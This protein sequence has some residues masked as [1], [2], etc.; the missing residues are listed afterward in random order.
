MAARWIALVIGALTFAIVGF[1]VVIALRPPAAPPTSPAVS[2]EDGA[3]EQRMMTKPW[4][5]SAQIQ[6]R[7]IG[8]EVM[9]SIRDEAGRPAIVLTAPRAELRMLEMSMAPVGLSLEQTAPGTWRGRAEPTMSGRWS[10]VVTIEGE[11][12]SFPFTAPVGK[13]VA[14]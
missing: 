8:L 4:T 14:S 13:P 2:S 12:L 3:A 5:V 1:F 6:P 7:P 10:F 9:L 11:E